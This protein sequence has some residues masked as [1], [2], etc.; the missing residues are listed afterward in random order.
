VR[1]FFESFSPVYFPFLLVLKKL[2]ARKYVVS[3]VYDYQNRIR[4]SEGKLIKGEEDR[5]AEGEAWIK[6]SVGTVAGVCF[7]L[8]TFCLACFLASSGFSGSLFVL[9]F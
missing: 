8:V 1:P 4:R 5:K 7:F 3:Q 9:L 2:K 6:L